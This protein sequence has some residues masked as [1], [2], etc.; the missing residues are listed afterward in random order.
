MWCLQAAAAEPDQPG[1]HDCEWCQPASLLLQ[2]KHTG[3][4][5]PDAAP[6]RPQALRNHVCAVAPIINVPLAW[7]QVAGSG[8]VPTAGTP[9]VEAGP[10]LAVDIPAGPDMGMVLQPATGDVSGAA[11]A[12][13]LLIHDQAACASPQATSPPCAMCMCACAC[14]CVLLQ[15]FIASGGPFSCVVRRL[16]SNATGRFMEVVAGVACASQ[17]TACSDMMLR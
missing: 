10:A 12:A 17:H 6:G 5:W 13:L 15:V 1:G 3:S 7:L 9:M 8:M 2:G 16:F 4:C 14:S 11:A